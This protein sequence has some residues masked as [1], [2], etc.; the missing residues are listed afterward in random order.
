MHDHI[1]MIIASISAIPTAHMC[2]MN[3]NVPT[4]IS[5]HVSSLHVE[6]SSV[7]TAELAWH[8]VLT[9]RQVMMIQTLLL[10]SPWEN[11]GVIDVKWPC[12]VL[13]SCTHA[14]SRPVQVLLV[15][16]ML[17]QCVCVCV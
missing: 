10:Y 13:V 2:I 1:I 6:L 16:H 11:P 15:P 9:T 8:P 5:L 17:T 14:L 7:L 12:H 3:E 4:L